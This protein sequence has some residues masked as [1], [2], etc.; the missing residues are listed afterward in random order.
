MSQLHDRDDAFD[1]VF[2]SAIDKAVRRAVDRVGRDPLAHLTEATGDGFTELPADDEVEEPVAPERTGI[3]P[4]TAAEVRWQQHGQSGDLAL[5]KGRLHGVNPH[6]VLGVSRTATWEQISAAYR[7]RARAWHPD[8]ADESER[9]RREE[10]IRQLN[11]AYNELR[12]RQARARHRTG[13]T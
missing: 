3:R 10:L 5:P 4:R 13:P 12:A 2:G 9:A 8:G 6:A 11:G 1:E 7:R